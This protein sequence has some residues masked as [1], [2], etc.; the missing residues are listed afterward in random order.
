MVRSPE[1]PRARDGTRETERSR[2]KREEREKPDLIRSSPN[3]VLSSLTRS[4]WQSGSDKK[5]P[6]RFVAKRVRIGFSYL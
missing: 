1:L 5:G 6:C 3:Q 2:E 4:T